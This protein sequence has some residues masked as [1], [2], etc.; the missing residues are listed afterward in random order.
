MLTK[1]EE[2]Y[3]TTKR[4][5]L[6]VI[7]ALKKLRHIIYVGYDT[8]VYSDHKPLKFLFRGTV[9]EGNWVDGLF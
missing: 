3:S 6:A 5:A 1:C 4:E 7:F 2:K 9:P 8:M